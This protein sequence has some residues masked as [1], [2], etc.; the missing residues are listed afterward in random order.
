M[1][2]LGVLLE[3][4]AG[5]APWLIRYNGPLTSDQGNRY[6]R[7]RCDNSDQIPVANATSPGM[8]RLITARSQGQVTVPWRLGRRANAGNG[9]Y[10]KSRNAAACGHALAGSATPE[11]TEWPDL[12]RM[13]GDVGGNAFACSSPASAARG[14]GSMKSRTF[15]AGYGGGGSPAPVNRGDLSRRRPGM[16]RGVRTRPPA[17][18]NGAAGRSPKRSARPG[19]TPSGDG[20]PA[21]LSRPSCASG[22]HRPAPPACGAAAPSPGHLAR[23]Q[24]AANPG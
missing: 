5:Q 21:A 1:N 10:V 4:G 14:S 23:R 6:V 8:T 18:P 2:N 3:D 16:G 17:A 12:A 24:A 15:W 20:E 9:L 13:P 22:Q 19:G 7:E 11:V